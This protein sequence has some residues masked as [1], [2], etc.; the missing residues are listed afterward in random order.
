MPLLYRPF[1]DIFFAALGG[2]N[3]VLE[4]CYRYNYWILLGMPLMAYS[5][6]ADSTSAARATRWF[7]W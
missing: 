1:S 6:L 3:M 2:E 5:I 4:E 7:L